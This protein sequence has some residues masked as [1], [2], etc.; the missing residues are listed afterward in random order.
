MWVCGYRGGVGNVAGVGLLNI[1]SVM[2]DIHT[3]V[4][5]TYIYMH[6]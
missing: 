1:V 4:T 3:V 2:A 6:N 5:C